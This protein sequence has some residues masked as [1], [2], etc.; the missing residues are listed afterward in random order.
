M[1]GPVSA[2][3]KHTDKYVVLVPGDMKKLDAAKLLSRVFDVNVDSL[4]RVLPPGG[5]TF[6]EMVR[7]K[8]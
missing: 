7:V 4:D 5:V 1:C 6:V 2:V 3:K 8:L